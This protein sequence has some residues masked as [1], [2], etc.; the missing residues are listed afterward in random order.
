MTDQTPEEQFVVGRVLLENALKL[1]SVG[2]FGS[3]PAGE[4]FT[5]IDALRNLGRVEVAQPAP[6]PPD[7]APTELGLSEE[8]PRL[9]A[10]ED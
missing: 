1:I 10:F 9:E 2:S 8:T 4:L 7:E 5:I 3:V 6:T